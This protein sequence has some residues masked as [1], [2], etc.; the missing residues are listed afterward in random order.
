VP[1][2]IFSIFSSTRERERERER[3]RRKKERKKEEKKGKKLVISLHFF[4]LSSYL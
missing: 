1:V 3:E 4:L 2:S